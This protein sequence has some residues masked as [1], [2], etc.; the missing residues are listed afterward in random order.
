MAL[1]MIEGRFE[2]FVMEMIARVRRTHF[3]WGK[4][5]K[6]ICRELRVSRNTRAQGDP[7]RGYG[8]ST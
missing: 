7:V 8:P 2:I 3:V 6:A 1:V 4:S 5:M